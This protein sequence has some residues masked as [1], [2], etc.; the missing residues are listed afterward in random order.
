MVTSLITALLF[1]ENWIKRYI[2]AKKSQSY[3]Q[4]D[5]VFALIAYNFNDFLHRH[6]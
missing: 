4:S 5:S 1:N 6:I 2:I 3:T